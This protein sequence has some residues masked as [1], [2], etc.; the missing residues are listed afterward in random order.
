MLKAV[1][2]AGGNG[3]RLWPKSKPDFPKQFIPFFNGQSMFQ[4]TVNRLAT[5]MR[6]ED[7]YVITTEK[8]IPYVKEQTELPDENIIVEPAAKDTAACIGLAA[9]H[10]LKKNIDPVLIT[11]PS[12][13]YIDGEEAFQ[14]AI[15]TAYQQAK[16]SPGVVTVGIKPNRPETAYGYIKV[17]EGGAG[18]ALPVERFTEKPDLE[19][20]RR[21]IDVPQYYWNSGIFVWKASVIRSLIEQH[22]PLLAGSLRRIQASIGKSDANHILQQ[23]YMDL[24][25]ISIDYGVLEK[26]TCIYLVPGS[27]VWDDLG[28]WTALE[29]LIDKDREG[30]VVVGE[31]E[32]LDTNNCIIY[33]EKAFVGAIGLEDLIITVTDQAVLI[34]H[35]DKEQEIKKL[36]LKNTYRRTGKEE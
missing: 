33:S 7:I 24:H 21:W 30:N 16:K 29:R 20:A 22:M 4:K 5:F 8:Y 23:E 11:L 31:H 10:F 3:T 14:T 19:T 6:F 9:I 1:I 36:F 27:F 15:M 17:K 32:L 13:Q 35:K 18:L 28:N 34:C 26:A 25:K 12:D 2:M